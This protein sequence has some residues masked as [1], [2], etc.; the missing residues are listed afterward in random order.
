MANVFYGTDND[1]FSAYV[2]GVISDDSIAALE[3]SMFQS[4]SRLT[5]TGRRF[6]ERAQERFNEIDYDLIKRRVKSL[7][8]KVSSFWDRNTVR[9]IDDIATMQHPG[10]TMRRWIM[11]SPDI[12]A[13]VRSGRSAGYS[14][15]YMLGDESEFVDTDCD[16]PDTDRL[17]Y[18]AV[19]NGMAQTDD[20]GNTYF[21]TYFDTF[22]DGYEELDI[23]EKVDIIHTWGN[24]FNALN[25][26]NGED[27]LDPN[28]GSL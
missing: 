13:R 16:L 8:R 11:A 24:V 10:E 25:V 19:M 7:K 23:S 22:E 28:N 3:K 5:D 18:K 9:E 1:Q 15:V 17:D 20:D 21:H 2:H 6:V 26:V 12:R 4:T 27:P 14:S